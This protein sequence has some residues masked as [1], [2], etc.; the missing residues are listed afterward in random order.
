M[1]LLTKANYAEL[2]KYPIQTNQKS[3]DKAKAVVKWFTP[4]S[5]W[6]WYVCEWGGPDDP[7]LFWGR[8][9]APTCTEWEYMRLSEIEAIKGP[10]G[11]KVE[12]DLHWTTAPMPPPRF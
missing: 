7:D 10:Y 1:K 4:W 11:L 8:T 5:N 2:A 9:D 12:R 6:T 3:L